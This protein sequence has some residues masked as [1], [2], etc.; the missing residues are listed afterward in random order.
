MAQ[1]LR[2]LLSNAIKFTPIEGTVEVAIDARDDR[3]EVRVRDSGVGI[4][5][6]N[7][8]RLFN[9]VV[10]FYAKAQQAVGGSG[11]GLWISRKIM[12]MHG[13]SIAVHSEGE[14]KG[15]VF[16]ISLP[17][18]KV[19][20]RQPFEMAIRP[21]EGVCSMHK[22]LSAFKK[23]GSGLI[24]N[25]SCKDVIE[26]APLPPLR[27]LVVDDSA[28]NRKMLMRLFVKEGYSVIEADDGDVAIEVCSRE[29]SEGRAF[30]LITMDNVS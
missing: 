14:G 28:L 2:N 24:K 19:D 4:S 10:Q 29:M 30:D 8:A 25:V 7:Q 3:L 16:L 17:M 22:Q 6:D 27:I 12:D 18:R 26:E 1:V 15:A 23:T 13:G 9:E 11:L 5:S 21:V 20:E